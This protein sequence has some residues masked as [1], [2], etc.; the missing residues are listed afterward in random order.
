V[1]KDDGNIVCLPRKRGMTGLGRGRGRNCV[2]N[3]VLAGGG[4]AGR[5]AAKAGPVPVQTRG[6]E[7]IRPRPPGQVEGLVKGKERKQ[8]HTTSLTL[9]E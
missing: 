2:N 3:R 9:K 4:G 7:D 1:P 8:S 6:V 5:P